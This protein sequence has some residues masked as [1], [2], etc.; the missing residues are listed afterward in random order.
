MEVAAKSAELAREVANRAKVEADKKAAMSRF[1]DAIKTSDRLIDQLAEEVRERREMREVAVFERQD[2]REG[3]IE[4]Y[5][6]DTGE[7]IRF[8]P[9]EP[10]DRQ[11][12]M[13]PR[14]RPAAV[15]PDDPDA[16]SDTDEVESAEH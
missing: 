7:V 1:A 11:A 9:M 16:D 4:V 10:T 3:R 2:L 8:R 6:G 13:F 15:G 14:V 12:E 5:R